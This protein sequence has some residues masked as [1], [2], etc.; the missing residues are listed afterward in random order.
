[1]D[2]EKIDWNIIYAFKIKTLDDQL[3]FIKKLGINNNFVLKKKW[4][5]KYRD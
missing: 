2:K 1:M 5:W 4:S 3:K